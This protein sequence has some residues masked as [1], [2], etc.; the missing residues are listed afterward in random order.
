MSIRLIE[1]FRNKVGVVVAHPEIVI[2]HDT[3]KEA[4]GGLNA[5]YLIFKEGALHTVDSLG[6]VASPCYEPC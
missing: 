6:S 2:I 1:V 3:L 4:D 5:G